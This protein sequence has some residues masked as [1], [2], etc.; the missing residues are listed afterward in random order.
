MRLDLTPDHD[1]PGTI[2]TSK[3]VTANDLAV[4]DFAERTCSRMML[5]VRELAVW[6]YVAMQ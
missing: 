2:A 3:D 1:P 4:S 5:A 6:K